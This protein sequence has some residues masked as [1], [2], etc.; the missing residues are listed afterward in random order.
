MF[1][2]NLRIIKRINGRKGR[3]EINL[4]ITGRNLR[5]NANRFKY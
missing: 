3:I 4:R 5:R 2:R 1:K